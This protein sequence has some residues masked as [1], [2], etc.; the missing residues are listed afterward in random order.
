MRTPVTLTW[1]VGLKVMDAVLSMSP[2]DSEAS[3]GGGRDW[4]DGGGA[5]RCYGRFV[6][7]VAVEPA[8]GGPPDSAASA[9]WRW[10]RR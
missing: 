9:W 10:R 5:G 4:A 8:A 1:A 3:A 7:A 6:G 2:A